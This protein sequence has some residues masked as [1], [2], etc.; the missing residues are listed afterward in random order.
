MSGANKGVLLP[1]A[2]PLML[3]ICHSSGNCLLQATQVLPNSSEFFIQMDSKAESSEA[4]PK[5]RQSWWE[6][7]QKVN[8]LE[9]L[10]YAADTLV[11]IFEFAC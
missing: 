1:E 3:G 9:P 11:M 8:K 10:A 5:M 4:S 2:S 6:K 7:M